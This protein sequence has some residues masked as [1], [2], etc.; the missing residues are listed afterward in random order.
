MFDVPAIE[1]VG[2]AA[3]LMIAISLMMKDIVKLRVLNSIGC[4]FFVIY[5]ITVGAYPVAI[6]NIAI[7]VINFYNL[8]TL[9]KT[10]K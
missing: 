7:I 8:Y 5:G 9:R 10:R 6:A 1:Y 4:L 3:S 2:Y